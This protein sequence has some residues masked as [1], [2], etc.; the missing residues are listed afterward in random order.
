MTA[1]SSNK[2]RQTEEDALSKHAKASKLTIAEKPDDLYQRGRLTHQLQLLILHRAILP[3]AAIPSRANKMTT[4]LQ[5]EPR[6]YLALAWYRLRKL[7]HKE[8]AHFAVALLVFLVGV[9]LH[10]MHVVDTAA[11]VLVAL[12][13]CSEAYLLWREFN[14]RAV[15]VD[16]TLIDESGFSTISSTLKTAR[17]PPSFEYVE[18]TFSKTSSG[19]VRS[20][21]GILRSAD[22]DNWLLSERPRIQL[23]PEAKR[24]EDV[25]LAHNTSYLSEAFDYLLARL[26]R[27][28][29]PRLFNE[30]KVS[31]RTDLAG[32]PNEV[33]V[34]RTSYLAS[35]LTNDACTQ[36]VVRKTGKGNFTYA[37]LTGMFPLVE[38]RSGIRALELGESMLSNH[39]GVSTIALIR[40]GD[41]KHYVVRPVQSASAAKSPNLYV[42]TG[43]GFT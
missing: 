7:D 1:S 12:L 18:L 3:L 20:I 9:A 28:G 29:Y 19:D 24:V 2:G 11:L 8:L 31:L 42:P 21:E 13:V 35:C 43:S 26:R 41:G 6:K 14:Q 17:M 5:R 33:I 38:E 10:L 25:I 15:L 30:D 27:T 40:Q 22:V 16:Q 34:G 37:D 23:R 32:R 39:I 36:R 4:G